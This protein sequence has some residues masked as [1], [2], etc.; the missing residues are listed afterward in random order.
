[1]TNGDQ[2]KIL[3]N[4]MIGPYKFFNHQPKAPDKESHEWHILND[5]KP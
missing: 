2:E 5:Q 3:N 1:M 4:N